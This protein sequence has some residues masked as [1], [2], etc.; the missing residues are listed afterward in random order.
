[1][2]KTSNHP[3]HAA[4]RG[5]SRAGAR[6]KPP[7]ARAARPAR[8]EAGNTAA[9]Q[10]PSR[11]QTLLILLGVVSGVMLSALDQSIVNTALPQIV[12][13]LG[14]LDLLSWVVTGYLLTSTAT[15]PLWGKLSDLYGR[16]RIFQSAI[17]IFLIGSVLC[18]V[19]Q[20]IGQ[21]IA[22]RAVQGMGGG[23]LFA[24]AFAI[25]GD[26]IPP[27]ER[28]RYQGYIGAVLGVFSVAGPL[29]GG[30]LTDGPGWRWTFYVNVP[31]GLIA[32]VITT[33]ALRVPG[34][35]RSHEIDYLGAATVVG[36]VT[37]LLLYLNWRGPERGWAETGALVLLGGFVVLTLSFVLV[38]H[39]AAEPILPL[40]LFGNSIFTIGNTYTFLAGTVILGAA[41]FLP[42]YLQTVRGMSPTESGLGTLPMVVGL[43]GASMVCGRL[44]TRTGRYKVYPILGGAL[45][46]VGVLALSR[47]DVDTPFWQTGLFAFV[48]GVGSGLTQQTITTAIQN[49]VERRDIGTA[50]SSVIFFRQIGGATGSAL[51]GAVFSTRLADRLGDAAAAIPN[52]PPIGEGSG[53]A[54]DTGQLR[55]LP[56][57][58]QDAVLQ[59]FSDSVG[60]VFLSAAP[61][62]AL[63]FATALFLK[64]RPLRGYEAAGAGKGDQPTAGRVPSAPTTQMPQPRLPASLEPS[65]RKGRRDAGVPV[66]AGAASP[67]SRSRDRSA[68]LDTAMSWVTS[69]VPGL[70]V[71]TG[72]AGTGKSA[73]AG[74]I[75]DLSAPAEWRR[76]GADGQDPGPAGPGLRSVVQAHVHARDLTGDALADLVDAQLVRA[77]VLPTARTG[78]RGGPELLDAV[79]QV[80]RDLGREPPVIVVDGLDQ[81]EEA[82]SIAHDVLVPLAAEA[83]V[84]VATRD[85]PASQG[86]VEPT[87][88]AA[89]RPRD[90]IDLDATAQA[91]TEKPWDAALEVDLDRVGA[92]GPPAL[93]SADSS[94]ALVRQ[95]SSLT[96][97]FGVGFP[98]DALVASEEAVARYRSL[99]DGD[100]AYRANLA[101]ALINLGICYSEAEHHYAALAATAEAVA[102][103]RLLAQTGASFRPHLSRALNNLGIC[104]REGGYHQKAIAPVEEATR[105]YRALAKGNPAFVP[106]LAMALHNLSNCYR[107]DGRYGDAL[108]LGE[109]AI[110]HHRSL[111]QA[112]P[113]HRPNLAAALTNLSISYSEACLHD[114]ALQPAEEAV[115]HYR[116]LTEDNPA[117]RENLATALSNLGIQYDRADRHRDAL[118]STRQALAHYRALAEDTLARGAAAGPPSSATVPDGGGEMRLAL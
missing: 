67:Q 86:A 117:Y 25:V 92:A 33:A 23:G 93:P 48:Y 36:A 16:R 61:F 88:L 8:A 77:A 51:L 71:I 58:V 15:T 38:E 60:D 6:A 85:L 44:I 46:A 28:G 53:A 70:R 27:R 68:E 24:V 94:S 112:D 3:S 64:E 82:F 1:M 37:S 100:P 17:V 109:E 57:A 69:G 32:L 73:V 20:N 91:P 41:V 14:G 47:L 89:L 118:A 66:L 102:H 108:A 9:E 10:Y 80:T 83:V 29:V 63:A 74:R 113:A 76:S 42:V 116:A 81:A 111:A 101:K 12:N 55:R 87:L 30:W 99:T 31:I 11:R 84:I 56:R 115:G 62:A 13:D 18:G 22:F 19:S 40:R 107:E 110:T 43:F 2:T 26:V 106:P 45:M 54:I 72:S 78:R 98:D 103:Y 75:V 21:L 90:I 34:T 65:S 39:R 35:R 104:Y 52:A 97:A 95:L 49:A 5:S 4:P 114:D 105:H 96:W 7:A 50:T 59:A 79:R